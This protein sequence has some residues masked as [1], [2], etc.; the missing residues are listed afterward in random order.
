VGVSV[1]QQVGEDANARTTDGLDLFPAERVDQARAGA[2]EVGLTSSPSSP[3]SLVVLDV[4]FATEFRDVRGGGRVAVEELGQAGFE[5]RGA[6]QNQVLLDMLHQFGSESPELKAGVA[7][8]VFAEP[9][10]AY[11]G[12][13]LPDSAISSG[14]EEMTAQFGST[15]EDARNVAVEQAEDSAGSGPHWRDADLLRD[16]L[17][18]F[19]TAGC[20][21]GIVVGE[22]T[23]GQEVWQV[24]LIGTAL[25]RRMEEAVR[26]LGVAL[27]KHGAMVAGGLRLGRDGPAGNGAQ[28]RSVKRWKSGFREHCVLRVSA[29][30]VPEACNLVRGPSRSVSFLRWFLLL[31]IEALLSGP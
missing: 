26:R 18:E 7:A 6:P 20:E 19:A 14:A 24:R 2:V 31:E 28:P 21:G 8:D 25:G 15:T 9:G 11:S 22:D 29:A 23:A 1:A 3:H 30:S 12:A 5:F 17:F 4:N 13:M 27:R 16:T 10:R